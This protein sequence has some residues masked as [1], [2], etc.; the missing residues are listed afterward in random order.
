[1]RG[2][3]RRYC[4]RSEA[5]RFRDWGNFRARRWAKAGTLDRGYNAHSAEPTR[6]GAREFVNMTP[7]DRPKMPRL[8]LKKNRGRALFRHEWCVFNGLGE[9]IASVP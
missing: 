4:E 1:M 3:R 9:V 6:S 8:R 2:A 5:I 7:S